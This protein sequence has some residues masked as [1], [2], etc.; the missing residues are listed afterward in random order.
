MKTEQ[1][2]GIIVALIIGLFSVYI[3]DYIPFLGA[4]SIA[5]LVGICINIEDL[6]IGAK[7]I[8]KK[9]L[10]IAIMFLGAT[11]QVEKVAELGGKSILVVLLMVIVT[12]ASAVLLGKLFKVD[13]HLA[14]LIGTGNAVCGSS[15]ILSASEVVKGDDVNVGTSIAII[16]LLG[17]VGIFL[18]PAIAKVFHFDAGVS[19]FYMGG[20]LQSVGNVTAAS[21]FVQGSF[22]LGIITKMVRVSSLVLVLVCYSFIFKSKSTKL[23]IP[24]FIIGFVCLFIIG[25]LGIVPTPVISTIDQVTDF[26]IVVC[27][28]AIGLSI[29]IRQI[30]KVGVKGLLLGSAN[31]AISLIGYLIC[32]GLLY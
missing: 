12:I 19:G 15:A 17:I 13:K 3:K 16:N 7:T 27:M 18:V 32:I 31:W 2:R 8:E 14:L 9:V 1:I 22:D 30:L 5:L 29:N 28:A 23:R 21:S 26:V 10:P 4:S 6:K 20:T 25:N 11:I 24:P